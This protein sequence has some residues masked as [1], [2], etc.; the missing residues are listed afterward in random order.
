MQYNLKINANLLIYNK[1]CHD[2]RRFHF[3]V[4]RLLP[5]PMSLS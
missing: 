5:T 1:Q 4:H 3:T 2:I